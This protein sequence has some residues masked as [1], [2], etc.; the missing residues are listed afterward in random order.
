MG[1]RRRAYRVLV[2][3]PEERE[4]LE[5]LDI[6]GKVIIKLTFTNWDEES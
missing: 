5:D 4:H 2:R 1:D 3:R 6:D